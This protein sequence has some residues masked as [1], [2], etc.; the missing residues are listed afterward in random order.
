MRRGL[1][2]SPFCLNT[3]LSDISGSKLD[4]KAK[5]GWVINYVIVDTPL[6]KCTRYYVHVVSK[7][8]RVTSV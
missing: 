6:N 5:T 2:F 4:A 3:P 1:P 7:L 8:S